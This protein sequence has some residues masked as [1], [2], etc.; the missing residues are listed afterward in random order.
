MGNWA[1][2]K[3]AL[4]TPANLLVPRDT[5]HSRKVVVF[6][7]PRTARPQP[8]SRL[9]PTTVP[10]VPLSRNGLPQRPCQSAD[11][12][13]A[14]LSELWPGRVP[15]ERRSQSLTLFTLRSASINREPSDFVLLDSL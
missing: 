2:Q 1:K 9:L 4:A 7:H 3:K 12:V 14:G 10:E 8:A 5:R 13:S 15:P 6:P 11:N